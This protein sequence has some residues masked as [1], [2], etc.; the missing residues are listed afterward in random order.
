[1]TMKTTSYPWDELEAPKG[2]GDFS[3]RLVG[4]DDNPAR[5]RIFWAKSWM[6][7]PA[8]IVE[9]DGSNWRRS[10]L[11]AFQ[12]IEIA[13]HRR[14]CS[15]SIELLDPTMQDIFHRVGLDIVN[16]LQAVSPKASRRACL[17]RLE[18]WSS[19][20]RPSHERMSPEK[21]KGLIAELLLLERDILEV[22]EGKTALE[23]WTGPED[24]PRDFAYGQTFIEVKSKR[25]SANPNIV[26]SSENQLNI[27]DAERLFLYVCELNS[28][29]EDDESSFS[30]NDM[31]RRVKEALDSPLFAA[32]LDAKLGHIGY[33]D[34]DDYSATRWTV[35]ETTY[36]E[37]T[38]GFP[39]L[40]SK[41]CVPGIHRVTY[42]VDLDYC[43]DYVADKATL[44]KVL[45]S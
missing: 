6:S 34:E 30:V 42:Q 24:G 22:Y 41:A 11:P 44:R 18:R 21:Q 14:E 29:P 32:Q 16:S 37:V 45:E 40:D 31:V 5:R 19:F 23:G 43:E 35:G 26:I 33:F 8:I 36:Y 27:S 10:T 25:S 2:E 28:A 9:Y 39:R 20:L 17:L 38:S 12:N 1:M 15:I 3:A 7:H 13:D 4:E